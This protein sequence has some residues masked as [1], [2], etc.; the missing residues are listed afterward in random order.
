MGYVH[1]DSKFL[2]KIRMKHGKVWNIVMEK[3]DGKIFKNFKWVLGFP[4]C[5]DVYKIIE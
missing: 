2:D 5:I 1:D 3:Y 4:W